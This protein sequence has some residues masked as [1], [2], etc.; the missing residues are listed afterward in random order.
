MLSLRGYQYDRVYSCRSD[1]DE[2][3]YIDL[4]MYM[5]QIA[6]RTVTDGTERGPKSGE[7]WCRV[8]SSVPC[9]GTFV[10][11]LDRRRMKVSWYI[12]SD[13]P[14]PYKLLIAEFSLY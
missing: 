7:M 13:I 11:L 2:N 12:N 4:S 3:K 1:G 5:A 9:F 14:P 6:R 10:T 8:A